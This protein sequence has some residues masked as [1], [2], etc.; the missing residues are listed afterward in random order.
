M[1]TMAPRSMGIGYHLIGV[2]FQARFS[3][4]D[5]GEGEAGGSSGH[6]HQQQLERMKYHHSQPYTSL[7]PSGPLPL[8]APPC[9]PSAPKDSVRALA[10]LF[11][12]TVAASLSACSGSLGAG[13]AKLAEEVKFLTEAR[14]SPR[15]GNE[16][17]GGDRI[18]D[19]ACFAALLDG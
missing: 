11:P 3:L 14:R 19:K 2:S 16:N 15:R 5:K 4:A 6:D 18:C 9:E 17:T 8:L 13:P 7:S 12:A 1:R 10:A